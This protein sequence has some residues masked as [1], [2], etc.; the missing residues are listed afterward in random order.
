MKQ[1]LEKEGIYS[2]TVKDIKEKIFDL[3]RRFRGIEDWKKNTGEGLRGEEDGAM[4]IKG[5]PNA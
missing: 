4:K 1:K 3:E 2:R 5:I